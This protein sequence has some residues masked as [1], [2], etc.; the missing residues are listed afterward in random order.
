[1][2]RTNNISLPHFLKASKQTKPYYMKFYPHIFIDFTV[3]R[4]KNQIN[5]AEPSSS[6]EGGKE[7]ASL[8]FCGS[9][10]RNQNKHGLMRLSWTL[11]D[12]KNEKRRKSLHMCHLKPDGWMD[13][14]KV[15]YGF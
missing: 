15:Y 11:G 9:T 14:V 3:Y 4:K 2:K 8:P 6:I 1:M 12:K 10:N 13:W 5:S 7:V